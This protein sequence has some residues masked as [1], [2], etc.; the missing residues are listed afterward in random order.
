MS[1]HT[2]PFE[3][4]QSLSS[5][6]EQYSAN[7]ESTIERLKQHLN[8]RGRDAVGY[9]L[10]SWFYMEADDKENAIDCALKSKSYAPG[11]PFLE[12]LHYFLVHPNA[13]E[14]W[15]PQDI[16]RDTMKI[17]QPSSFNSGNFL[18][19]LESL[20]SRLSKVDGVKIKLGD[21]DNRNI[22]LSDQSDVSDIATETLAT[23]HKNQGNIENAISI[24]K[25]LKK[26]H[27]EKKEYYKKQIKALQENQKSD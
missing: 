10:L 21:K 13:F 4:P 5:Y 3:L 23:I 17:E 7:P 15:I 22:D 11:S 6:L 27:P 16:H 20:I 18:V 26:L 1:T 9:F 2:F 25:M 19:N 14:A 24:Y 12:Y 8:R